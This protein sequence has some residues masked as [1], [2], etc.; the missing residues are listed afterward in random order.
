MGA[1]IE[2][3]SNLLRSWSTLVAPYVGAWIE[4]CYN[5]SHSWICESHPTWVRGLKPVV[6]MV[7]MNHFVS[8]P[9]WVRGLKHVEHRKNRVCYVAP[10][11]GAWIETESNREL[12]EQQRVSHPTWVRGLKHKIN[13]DA[14][15]ALK[16]HP[17]W[18]RGLKQR[19]TMRLMVCL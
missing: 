11:V 8:H 5:H 3:S 10:Y 17:T 14:L 19:R 7:L 18:V 6:S 13:A 12:A 15:K 1:W 9:T 4:T 2:T 16:S